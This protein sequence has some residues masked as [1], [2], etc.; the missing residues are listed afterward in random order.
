VKAGVEKLN[1]KKGPVFNLKR[2]LEEKKV[3]K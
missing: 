3:V 2:G 1:T